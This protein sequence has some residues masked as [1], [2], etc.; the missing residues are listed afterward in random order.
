VVESLARPVER[1]VHA[2]GQLEAV[3]RPKTGG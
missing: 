1:Q 2:N 3:S